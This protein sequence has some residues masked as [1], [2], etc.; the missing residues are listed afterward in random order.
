MLSPARPRPLR[1][2]VD[3]PYV[4][5]RGRIVLQPGYDPETHLYLQLP[6][7]ESGP[8]VTVRPG[9]GVVRE[10]LHT[11]MAPWSAYRFASPA[12]AAGM[13]SAVLA[14]VSRGVLALCPAYLF[15]AASQGSGKS[16]AACALGA[17]IEGR[18]PA[19]TPFSGSGPG[20]DDEL[21]KRLVSEAAEGRRFTLIDNVVGHFKSSALAAVLTS[22]RLADRVLGQSRTVVA[23]VT[24]LTT[25]T[26]NN[27]SV[28]A[29]LS[30]R[31]VQ[32]RIEAGIDPTHRAFD[33][34]PVSVALAQRRRIA[35]AAC[36]VLAAYFADGASDIV[37]GDAGGFADWNRLCRQP[38]LWLARK[39]YGDTLPWPEVGDPAASMLADP[40]DTDPEVEATGDLLLALWTITDGGSFTAAD[41]AEWFG[42]GEDSGDRESPTSRVHEAVRDCL[43]PRCQPS[44]RSLGRMLMYRRDRAIGGLKLL[45][46][47]GRASKVWRVALVEPPAG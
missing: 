38:V 11:M 20:A 2:V 18:L 29:D 9:S 33:F 14:A 46:R 45:G 27:A 1:A 28:D 36:T 16:K 41:V 30:R 25:L 34:D 35:E 42:A 19:V 44:A 32:V 24:A 7:L 13:V 6:E 3:L 31:M 10:A 47:E 37:K 15:D 22:G 12:D 4:T 43:G 23:D 17:V 8:R 21:R 26:A 40:A 5:P 39:G